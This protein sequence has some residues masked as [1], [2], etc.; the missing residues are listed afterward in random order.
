[1]NKRFLLLLL[2]YFFSACNPSKKNNQS[3]IDG[4]HYSVQKSTLATNGTVVSAHSL[5]SRVGVQIMKEGGNAIDAAIATQLALAVVYPEAGNLGGG[6]FFVAHLADGRNIAI[7]FREM[8]PARASRDMYIDSTGVARTDLSQNGHLS[9][10]IPGTV[11][12]LFAMMQY[13]KLPFE[14][15][16]QPAIDLAEN[17]FVIGKREAYHLNEIRDEL[18]RYNTLTPVFIKN[19]RWHE[20]DTL[21]QTDLASTLKRI[22][23]KGAAGFYE[24]ETARLIIQEMKRANGII[25]YE[26]LRNYKALTREPHTFNYKGY[27]IIGMPMPSS[28]GLLLNQMMKMVENRDIGKMGFHSPEATQLMIEVERRAFADRAEY[29]GD[30]DFYK[31]PVKALSSD[32]YLADR[33]KDYTPGKAGTSTVIKPGDPVPYESTETTH[34]SILDKDGNA[35]SVTTTLNNSYGSKTVVGG[36]GFFLND[37]MDDFSI[38]PGVANMYGAVGGDANAIKP[39]KRMLSSMAPTIVLKDNVPVIV[40]GTPGGTTIPTSVF[41]TLLNIIEFGMTT[42]EAV[43]QPKFHHQWLPDEVD[44]ETGFPSAVSMQLQKMGYTIK[45]RTEIGR[46]E[47]IKVLPNGKLEGIADRRGEDDA[48]GW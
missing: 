23:E 46:T 22:R 37:E 6:G 14:K 33:M 10:G 13:A 43:N 34:L 47:V 27:M 44:L 7:D 8:A 12:G 2:I 11:A 30:A 21:V 24:G 32:K 28:G 15:L 5:A 26:D 3:S 20:A 38:K 40:A 41:Q 48:E 18:F 36:A 29:M 39:G 16:I 42:E 9:A 45:D 35:V 4:Y 31:V 25:T 1:M 19:E 17:G